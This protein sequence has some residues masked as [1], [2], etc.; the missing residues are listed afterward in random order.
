MAYVELKTMLDA[1]PFLPVEIVTT[2]GRVFRITHREMFLLLKRILIVKTSHE[3]AENIHL[4]RIASATLQ[5]DA[6]E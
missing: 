5:I 3:S 4:D 6:S 1:H 2:D